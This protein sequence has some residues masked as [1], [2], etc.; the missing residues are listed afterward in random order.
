MI[1]IAIGLQKGGVGK[2]TTVR[3]LAA[4]LAME[5]DKNV[6]MIDADSQ[7]SLTGICNARSPEANLSHVLDGEK[8]LDDIIV[9]VGERMWLAPSNRE[10]ANTKNRLLVVE[11]RELRLKRA[12]SALKSDFDYILIDMPPA[13]DILA[14]NVLAAADEVLIPIV[15]GSMEIEALAQFY[16][17]INRL[18]SAEEVPEWNVNPG[19]NVLGVLVNQYQAHKVAHKQLKSWMESQGYPL[20]PIEIGSYVAIVESSMM[21]QS[22]LE[23]D[24]N[25]KAV[26]Q[27]RELARIID[28]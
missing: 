16:D 19:L 27:Y 23:Y 4:V 18:R 1:T 25:H 21:N 10:L 17:T 5:H 28:K 11:S 2:T 7:A 20:I 14:V 9:G 3:N 8:S 12:I 24:P 22:L 26:D 15:L 6:L 13:L